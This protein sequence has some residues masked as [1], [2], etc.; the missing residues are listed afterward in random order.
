MRLVV[1]RLE[2]S[3]AEDL[4][5]NVQDYVARVRGLVDVDAHLVVAA[6]FAV[7]HHREFDGVSIVAVVA[8][9]AHANQR[10]QRCFR[11]R[12]D[13]RRVIGAGHRDQ[14]LG[15]VELVAAP[16]H[17]EVV[18]EQQV[19]VN[20]QSTR[21]ACGAHPYLAA[22]SG[23]PAETRLDAITR[24]GH[25][26]RARLATRG[27]VEPGSDGHGSDNCRVAGLCGRRTG[28][29]VDG[30]DKLPFANLDAVDQYV[31]LRMRSLWQRGR[32]LH[33]VMDH[34][35]AALV[36]DRIGRHGQSVGPGGSRNKKQ[37]S[38]CKYV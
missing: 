6:R 15:H 3:S 24:V 34:D 4:Q 33:R 13:D 32:G 38:C 21:D 25:R 11:R 26:H 16:V 37:D 36:T 12:L 10:V 9:G 23:E 18:R 17:F 14:V 20:G 35:A 7:I 27:S 31:D 1:V 30:R 22:A 2:V 29:C 28:E 8:T 19:A 5:R